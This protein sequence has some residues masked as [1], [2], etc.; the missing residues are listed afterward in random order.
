MEILLRNRLQFEPL[1]PLN[2]NLVACKGAKDE[3]EDGEEVD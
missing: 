2:V 1:Y 3:D